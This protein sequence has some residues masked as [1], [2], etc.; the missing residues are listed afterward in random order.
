MG[1]M[2]LEAKKGRYDIKYIDRGGFHEHIG[3]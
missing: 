3:L 2:I 1:I